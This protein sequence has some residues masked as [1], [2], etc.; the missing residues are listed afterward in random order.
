M[1]AIRAAIE[2]SHHRTARLAGF[3]VEAVIEAALE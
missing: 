2:I 1:I 3:C